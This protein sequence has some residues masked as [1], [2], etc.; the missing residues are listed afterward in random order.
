MTKLFKRKPKC[1]NCGKRYKTQYDIRC[2]Y[3]GA[4][5]DSSGD[6]FDPAK[7][8]RK[9]EL[10]YGPPIPPT[11]CKCNNCGNRWYDQKLEELTFPFENFDDFES[12]NDEIILTQNNES[13][14]NDYVPVC[15]K[16]GEPV[17]KK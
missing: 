6:A 9:I 16:C 17:S 8:L 2:Y 15:P 4:S 12:T 14:E 7:N 5:R 10:L 13:E 3:C 1:A 11:N